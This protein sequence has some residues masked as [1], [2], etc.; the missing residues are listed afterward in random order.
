METVEDVWAAIERVRTEAGSALDFH[1]VEFDS[2]EEVAEL[3]SKVVE[4][5]DLRSLRI[6]GVDVSAGAVALPE[7][8]F[9]M[10]NLE[11]LQIAGTV[12]GLPAAIRNLTRLRVLVLEAYSYEPYPHEI[13][14]LRSLRKLAFVGMPQEHDGLPLAKPRGDLHLGRLEALETLGIVRCCLYDLPKEIGLLSSLKELNLYD[15]QQIESV[16]EEIANLKNLRRLDLRGTC[17]GKKLPTEMRSR[18]EL[19]IVEGEVSAW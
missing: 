1:E 7:A 19:E 6:G 3:L 18:P 11:E 13:F 10:K 16:P 9:Q 2:A 5:A 14:E 12:E 17:V 15:S 8:L 4:L